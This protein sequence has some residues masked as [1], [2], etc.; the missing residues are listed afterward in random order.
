MQADYSL[1]YEENKEY[2]GI[3]W[4]LILL[5]VLIGLSPITLMYI[6]RK[7]CIDALKYF[8]KRKKKTDSK[9]NIPLD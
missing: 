8:L 9:G 5:W 4:I 7:G 6:S 2:H 3:A 1:K